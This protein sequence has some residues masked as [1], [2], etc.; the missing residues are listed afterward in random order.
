[1]SL[2]TLQALKREVWLPECGE[3]MDGQLD[4]GAF[5][6]L[7]NFYNWGPSRKN[8]AEWSAQG[9]GYSAIRG[10]EGTGILLCS[11]S[12]RDNVPL[13]AK[14]L[15]A[16]NREIPYQTFDRGYLEV[17][18]L[19]KCNRTSVLAE[20]MSRE[21]YDHNGLDKLSEEEQREVG[22]ILARLQDKSL[23]DLVDWFFTRSARFGCP[24]EPKDYA[25]V[26]G[27]LDARRKK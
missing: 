13:S 20:I 19:Q 14:L 17:A 4:A 1:M 22:G 25:S 26:V 12:E 8:E 11:R 9:I 27:F 5:R 21:G 24:G 23:I 15:I 16:T 2:I 6:A 7:N 3:L 18:L 10:I